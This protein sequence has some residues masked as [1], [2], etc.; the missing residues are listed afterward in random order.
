MADIVLVSCQTIGLV[1]KVEHLGLGYLAAVLESDGYRVE[2]VDASFHHLSRSDVCDRVLTLTPP[3]LGFSVYY[4]NVVETLDTIHELRKRGFAGHI[5]LGGHHATFYATE[6]LVDHPEIDSIV[7]GE[8]EG[9]ALDLASAVAAGDDWTSIPNLALRMEGGVKCNP[10]RALI[11]DLNTLPFPHRGG[12]EEF[13]TSQK[14]ASVVSSRGCHGNCGFCSIRAFYGISKGRRWRARS[15]RS[16]V[17]EIEN[18]VERFG[19]KRINFL[20]DEFIGPGAQSHRRALEIGKELR[21][22]DLRIS[23]NIVCR[24]DNLRRSTLAKLK[25]AGLFHVSIGIESWVPRQLELLGKHSSV[26]QNN[27]A[28]EVI[29][30]LGLDYLY[31]LIPA[32][33]WVTVEELTENLEQIEAAGIQ[34]AAEGFTFSKLVVFAGTRLKDQLDSAGLLISDDANPVYEGPCAYEFADP[35]VRRIYQRWEGLYC[36]YV[37][38]RTQIATLQ[39]NRYLGGTEEV[40]NRTWQ[41]LLSA[42][43]H[44]MFKQVVL[45]ARSGEDRDF[46][47]ELQDEIDDL[48]LQQAI[49][50]ASPDA[51]ASA[52][53]FTSSKSE[54]F[55]ELWRRAPPVLRSVQEQLTAML[56]PIR[57]GKEC[58]VFAHAVRRALRALALDL[59]DRVLVACVEGRTEEAENVLKEGLK[60]L[61]RALDTVMTAVEENRFRRF[62]SV[63]LH[64]GRTRVEYP[65]AAIQNLV[66]ELLTRVE[67]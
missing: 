56:T 19:V 35:C 37:T 44:R 18:L 9:A 34:H 58:R 21:R 25:E 2:I 61:D 47:T 15:P 27:E 45:A 53:I 48:V 60:E 7:R 5:T 6:M 22:R 10:C 13:L 11:R 49:D 8:G 40:L 66:D 32:D 42:S 20:D 30:E 16:V 65:P 41:A 51:V 59:G 12:Y 4:N 36:E 62:Q 31:F 54:D 17:N 23:F 64:L 50:T 57:A 67:A 28:I 14:M 29:R 38:L 55:L 46:E 3:L 26:Q 33:P 63:E 1:S 43:A 24:P 39:S 52:G